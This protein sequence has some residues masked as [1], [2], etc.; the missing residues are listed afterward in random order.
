L[1]DP[2]RSVAKKLATTRLPPTKRSAEPQAPK[3]RSARGRPFADQPRKD[4]PQFFRNSA[5]T[6]SRGFFSV[7]KFF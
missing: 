6:A 4:K 7:R 2:E 5:G 1:L 3:I